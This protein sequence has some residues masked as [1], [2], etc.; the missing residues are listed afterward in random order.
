MVFWNHSS[1]LFLAASD[2]F[3]FTLTNSMQS[4]GQGGTHN[5]HPVHKSSIT[6]CIK[7]E[8]PWIASTGH[9]SMHFLQP[10]H[11]SSIMNAFWLAMSGPKSMSREISSG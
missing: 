4:T 9:A 11:S 2:T 3:S 8:A 7:F 5:S 1:E 10:I 6:L